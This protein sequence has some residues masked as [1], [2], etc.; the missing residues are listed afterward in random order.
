MT[1]RDIIRSGG[2][3]RSDRF[4]FVVVL[5]FRLGSFD[6]LALARSYAVAVLRGHGAHLSTG[7]L[8]AVPAIAVEEDRIH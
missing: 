1:G 3:Y 8:V 5:L 4:V 6:L 7:G 2:W